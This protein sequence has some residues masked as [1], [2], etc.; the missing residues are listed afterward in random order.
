MGRLPQHGLPSDVMSAPRI[1]T[2]EP[3]AIKAEHVNL[4]AMPPGR[5]R[6]KYKFKTVIFLNSLFTLFSIPDIFDHHTCVLFEM[7]N[8]LANVVGF[9]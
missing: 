3:R 7:V 8:M 9:Y 6:K 1:Q 2:G 5:P 4:T